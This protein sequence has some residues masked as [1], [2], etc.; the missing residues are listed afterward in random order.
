MG[1]DPPTS[2]P[3]SALPVLPLLSRCLHQGSDGENSFVKRVKRDV[4][5]VGDGEE[6]EIRRRGCVCSQR[7]IRDGDYILFRVF[8]EDG[9][10]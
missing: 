10:T 6:T 4:I 7:V 3:N 9:W 5:D 2:S 1:F 8:T